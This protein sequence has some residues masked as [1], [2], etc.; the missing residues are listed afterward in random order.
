MSQKNAARIKEEEV[1]EDPVAQTIGDPQGST[2]GEVQAGPQVELVT[3]DSE[4][5]RES[6]LQVGDSARSARFAPLAQ[7]AVSGA[8]GSVDLLLDVDL[9]LTVELGR[10]SVPVREILQLGPGSILELDKLAGDSVDIMVNGRLIARGEV[11]V[12]DENFGVRVTEIASPTERLSRL[13]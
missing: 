1:A 2:S 4:G 13:A 10:A 5:D 9:N 12:V 8:Q 7:N 6:A 11:V 3:S